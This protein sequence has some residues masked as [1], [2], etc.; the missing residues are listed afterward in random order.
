MTSGPRVSLELADSH[1][2]HTICHIED[3]SVENSTEIGVLL[4]LDHT[5]D[6]C[7]A[8]VHCLPD[9]RFQHTDDGGEN[10][11]EWLRHDAHSKDDRATER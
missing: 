10:L 7:G 8:E 9:W 2:R 5:V 4:G 3:G 6:A 11:F 1:Q